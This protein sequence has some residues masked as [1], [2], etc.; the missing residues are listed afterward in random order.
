MV[1]FKSLPNGLLLIFKKE[2]MMVSLHETLLKTFHP[3]TPI[4][5]S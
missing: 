2:I 3:Q 5:T 4:K 1:D